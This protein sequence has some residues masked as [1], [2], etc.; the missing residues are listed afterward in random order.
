MYSIIKNLF[1]GNEAT[2]DQI[3]DSEAYN[4]TLGK[5]VKLKNKLCENLT[6]EQKEILQNIVELYNDLD[7]E[8]KDSAFVYGFKCGLKIAAECYND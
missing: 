1:Y 4:K 7:V 5:L 3:K 2:T 6:D 8:T